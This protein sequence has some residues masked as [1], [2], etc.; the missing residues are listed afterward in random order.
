MQELWLTCIDC[1]KDFYGDEYMSHNSCMSEDQRYSKEG[2]SGWDPS[3]GQ[4]H[5]G[6][7]K[8]NAWVNNLRTILA[9]TQDLDS[10]VKTIVNTIMDH[11]NIPRK[12]PKF[13][14]FVKNIMRNR[15]RPHSMDKTWELFSQAL[16]PPEPQAETKMEVTE[17][18]PTVSDEVVE[19]SEKKKK[20]KKKNK[21]SS[22]SKESPEET[23]SEKE[24]VEE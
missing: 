2:R 18:K 13:V 24:N 1:L 7:K 21:E 15:A 14:N 17:D 23:A 16:K 10:D 22:Q 8:Q 20:K 11:E 5:K 6:E 9:E 3:K 4:G 12:K 19:T